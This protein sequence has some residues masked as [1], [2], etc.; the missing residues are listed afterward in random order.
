MNQCQ[1]DDAYRDDLKAATVGVTKGADDTNRLNR[2][3][4]L[5]RFSDPVYA[6]AYVTV[7]R[8]D[9]AVV[10]VTIINRT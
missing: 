4:Q 9:N 1:L 2:F 5:T 10:D 3:V 8:Y 7:K 6:E